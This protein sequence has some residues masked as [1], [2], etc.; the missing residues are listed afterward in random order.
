MKV[1]NPVPAM[2]VV[3]EKAVAAGMVW[4][5][6]SSEVPFVTLMIPGGADGKT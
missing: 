1:R 6:F 2:A 5:A 4:A 3:Q